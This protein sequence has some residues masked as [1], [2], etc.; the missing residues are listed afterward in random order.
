[1]GFLFIAR[2]EVFRTGTTLSAWFEEDLNEGQPSELLSE[3]TKHLLEG[4][5]TT[6]PTFFK[7]PCIYCRIGKVG[8]IDMA[9]IRCIHSA[10]D[11]RYFGAKSVRSFINIILITVEN[12]LFRKVD[13]YEYLTV[14]FYY[15]V[16][17][18]DMEII[19]ITAEDNR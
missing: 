3:A 14:L 13:T 10:G 4:A 2:F 15:F 7:D 12:T 16:R 19:S 8:K 5:L 9:P 11:I 18:L 17:N 6:N 1:M